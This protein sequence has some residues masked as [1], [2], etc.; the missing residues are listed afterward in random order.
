M[1]AK[2]A[3]DWQALVQ[4]SEM[5]E[6]LQ[7]HGERWSRSGSPTE[8]GESEGSRCGATVQLGLTMTSSSH[9]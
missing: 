4:R 9:G 5:G 1:A 7:K 3:V 8:G 2:E 6:V